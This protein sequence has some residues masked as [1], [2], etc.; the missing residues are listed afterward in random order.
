MSKFRRVLMSISFL[1]CLFALTSAPAFTAPPTNNDLIDALMLFAQA[2]NSGTIT[3]IEEATLQAGEPTAS[4]ADGGTDNDSIWFKFSFPD[5]D[6]TMTIATVEAQFSAVLTLYAFPPTGLL[7]D[8]VEIACVNDTGSDIVLDQALGD[9]MYLIR[10]ASDD[11]LPLGFRSATYNFVFTPPS[12]GLVPAN[13]NRINAAPVVFNK[14]QKTRNFEYATVEGLD[15]NSV[16]CS[17]VLS[18]RQTLWYTF[19]GA[20]GDTIV[21]AEGSSMGFPLQNYLNAPNI[22]L[23]STTGGILTPVA[24]DNNSGF[25][26]AGRL[27]FDASPSLTYVVMVYHTATLSSMTTPSTVKLLVSPLV[28]DILANGKFEAGLDNWI[29]TN[30]AGDALATGAGTPNGNDAFRFQ[31]G[32]NESTQLKQKVVIPP[33]LFVPASI[34]NVRYKASS[35]TQVPPQ[36]SLKLVLVVAF[37]D[38]T[39]VKFKSALSHSTQLLTSFLNSQSFFLERKGAKSI[40]LRLKN[41]A[42]SGDLAI[43]D[44]ELEVRAVSPKRSSDVLPLPAGPG[45]R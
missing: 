12:A 3:D 39:T 20:A 14:S 45:G 34:L 33:S 6:I 13:D 36:N 43:D 32:P 9:G 41:K 44:L 16:S 37:A 19:T 42:T 24:C 4:C 28:H 22:A 1:V 40:Q 7:A 31:G 38:G 5:G 15:P 27:I 17:G 23:F 25:N 26:G 10:V 35:L 30:A 8:M 21:S 18:P 2:N 11:G 29:V